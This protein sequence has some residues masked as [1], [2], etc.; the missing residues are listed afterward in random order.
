MIFKEERDK[1]SEYFNKQEGQ[2]YPCSNQIVLCGFVTKDDS[3]WKEFIRENIKDI[4]AEIVPTY[5]RT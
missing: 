5:R 1:I 3:K 4:V 2:K